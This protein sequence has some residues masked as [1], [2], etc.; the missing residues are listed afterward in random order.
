MDDSGENTLVYPHITILAEREHELAT[1]IQNPDSSTYS[2]GQA[3]QELALSWSRFAAKRARRFYWIPTIDDL[4]Q[5]AQIALLKAAEK[6]QPDRGSRFSGYA[7][8]HIDSAIYDHLMKNHNIVRIGSS[9]EQR[10][11]YYA[12]ARS[13]Q[14]G[15]TNFHDLP[16]EEV[17]EILDVSIGIVNGVRNALRGSRSLDEK[18]KGKL[19]LRGTLSH[20][21]PGPDSN[22]Q[23][24]TVRGLPDFLADR[25]TEYF[26]IQEGD[27]KWDRA[28][29]EREKYIWE[30]RINVEDEDAQW[31]LRQLGDKMGVT[32]ER[33][34]QIEAS[35]KTQLQT[36]TREILGTKE[37]VSELF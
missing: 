27:S 37:K 9:Q 29:K 8:R 23:Y 21:G 24:T 6:Y 2:R 10:K 31:T 4:M 22:V 17:S 19:T 11:V 35:F 13:H 33:A 14:H 20:D 16:S 12:F 25:C 3:I 36:W 15:T 28:R 5:D 26:T 32:R 34:R 18:L 30:L 7:V 1:I